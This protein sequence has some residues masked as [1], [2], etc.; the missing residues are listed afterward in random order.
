MR[1]SARRRHA[2][3][4]AVGRPAP[5]SDVSPARDT[6]Q[7]CG[8]AALA[9]IFKV[10]TLCPRP[11]GCLGESVVDISSLRRESLLFLA[12]LR[13]RPR[14]LRG[15]RECRPPEEPQPQLRGIEVA[16]AAHARIASFVEVARRWSPLAQR[17]RAPPT[18]HP[19]RRRDREATDGP[20]RGP[21]PARRA[22][23]R[24]RSRARADS[25][26]GDRARRRRARARTPSSAG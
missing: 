9:C 11:A 20:R 4:V 13:P 1:R 25:C 3:T 24:P 15:A 7:R 19:P 8:I 21:R 16:A 5:R 10:D 2:S 14:A 26:R 6:G 22:R 23:S 17:V 12:R 18:A